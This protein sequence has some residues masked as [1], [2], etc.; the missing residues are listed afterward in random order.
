MNNEL[1]FRPTPLKKC[2][3]GITIPQ[4]QEAFYRD[5]RPDS[6]KDFAKS[7]SKKLS[8]CNENFIWNKYESDIVKLVKKVQ[9]E[10]QKL[11]VTVILDFSLNHLKHLENYDVVTII[12]HWISHCEKIE[13]ADGIYST[14]EFIDVIP[15][16]AGCMLDLTVCNSTILADEIKKHFRKI[17]VFGFE[18]PISIET[19][20]LIYKYIIQVMY[21]DEKLNYLD[22]FSLVKTQIINNTKNL[23]L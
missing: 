20:L 9:S 16:N 8:G 5:L 6:P 18:A 7:F 15:T 12:G 17:I 21:N 4:T 14:N 13:L 19:N 1:T 11:G 23:F 2:L 22:A 10:V 3:L